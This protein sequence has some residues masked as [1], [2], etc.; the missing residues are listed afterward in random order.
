[1]T[2]MG[3]RAGSKFCY[4]TDPTPPADEIGPQAIVFQID[5]QRP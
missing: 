3:L 1:M 4:I 5:D 2:L